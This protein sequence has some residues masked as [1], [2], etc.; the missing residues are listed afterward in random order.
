MQLSGW[1][2]F[3]GGGCCCCCCC[4]CL[5]DHTIFQVF[6]LFPTKLDIPISCSQLSEML[7]PFIDSSI[8]C[9]SLTLKWFSFLKDAGSQLLL[10]GC[11]VAS[12]NQKTM[13]FFRFWKLLRLP[14]SP[15]SSI[16]TRWVLPCI[17]RWCCWNEAS[18]NRS[19]RCKGQV[20][21]KEPAILIYI[22]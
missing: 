8:Y 5:K 7:R 17:V 16:Q 9:V 18:L 21:T 13:G 10:E 11:F 19:Y 22:N 20:V 12:H 6:S 1:T 14:W 4:C 15:L 3:G 2:F